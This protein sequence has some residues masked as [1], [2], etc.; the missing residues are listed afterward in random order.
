MEPHDLIDER[1]TAAGHED[2]AK[3]IVDRSAKV[4]LRRR[5][6]P[7]AKTVAAKNESQKRDG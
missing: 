2:E 7:S 5:G 6:A 4:S 1:G 3:P